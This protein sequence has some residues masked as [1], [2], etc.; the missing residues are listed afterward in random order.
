M[1]HQIDQ[2][3]GRAAMFSGN[4]ITPWHQLGNVVEGRL[5]AKDAIT[6]AGLDWDVDLAPVF[7]TVG[8]RHIEIPDHYAT[9]RK[10]TDRV[11]GIVGAKY[12]PVQNVEMFDFLDAIVDSGEAHYETA[13]SLRNGANVWML[14]APDENEILLNGEKMRKYLLATTS[15]DGTASMRVKPVM[16][17]VVCANTLDFALSE[18]ANEFRARHTAGVQGKVAQAREALGISFA[19]F[20]EFERIAT[21]LGDID[22]E[23]DEFHALVQD[24]VPI[25]A[26]TEGRA[27]T[28]RTNK[29]AGI[30]AAY[31]SDLVGAA[32]GTGWGVVQA[33][34]SYELWG[35]DGRADAENQ[36]RRLLTG[37]SAPLTDRAVKLLLNN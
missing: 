9:Y 19:Y 25:D 1:A 22:V 21:Q 29:R 20:E 18:R 37:T 35:T 26:E 30:Q 2:S 28:I 12:N 36:A 31:R 14:L 27:L 34:N 32:R 3:T 8:E 24:L 7:A 13:G 10:D 15:H 4:N 17:R 23:L 11:L 16:E 6:Q 33:V 5:H